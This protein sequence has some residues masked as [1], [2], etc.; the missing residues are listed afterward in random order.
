M[1]GKTS[2]ETTVAPVVHLKRALGVWDL[3]WLAIV[4]VANMNVLPVIAAN[5]PATLWLWMT[6]LLFFFLPQGLGVIELSH[7]YPQEGGVYAWTKEMFGDLHGFLAGWCYWTANIFYIPTL[8]FYL[9]GIVTYTGG[10]SVAK[11]GESSLIF[12]AFAIVL[13]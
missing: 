11:L 13:L 9:L 10:A 7:R 4:A 6:A 1:D 2:A 12:G 3:M 5:G 8:V